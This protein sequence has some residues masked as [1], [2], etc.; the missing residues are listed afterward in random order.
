[1]RLV[2]PLF[3]AVLLLG[4]CGDESSKSKQLEELREA[5]QPDAALARCIKARTSIGEDPAKA[6]SNCTLLVWDD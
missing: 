1:M 3:L 5:N 2:V 4:A 6:R